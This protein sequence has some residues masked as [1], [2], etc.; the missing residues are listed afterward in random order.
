[1]FRAHSGRDK[2]VNSPILFKICGFKS[3]QDSR[4]LL[5]QSARHY[6][7]SR[8]QFPAIWRP[9]RPLLPAVCKPSTSRRLQAS[10]E[11]RW[12]PATSSLRASRS[13]MLYTLRLG[14]TS[15]RCM[16]TDC[17]GPSRKY[18]GLTVPLIGKIARAFLRLPES[19]SVSDCQKHI[20]QNNGHV[21]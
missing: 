19:L 2:A 9:C 3:S 17:A 8:G 1:M 16:A 20:I 11:S 6:I 7:C 10:V 21:V 14:G 4:G 13:E 18:S 12:S 5:A 15:S